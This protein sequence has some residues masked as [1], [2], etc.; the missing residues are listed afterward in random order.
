MLAAPTGMGLAGCNVLLSSTY[1]RMIMECKGVIF[2][3]WEEFAMGKA[4]EV[5]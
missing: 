2:A 4:T 1:A 5:D 3:T